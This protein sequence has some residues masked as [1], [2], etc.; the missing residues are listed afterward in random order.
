MKNMNEIKIFCPA[1]VANLSCGFDIIGLC[2][3]GI[4]DE[5]IIKKT[6]EKGI[7]ISVITGADLPFEVSKNV[8]GVAA[9]S[10]YNHLQPECGFEIEIHKKIK[11]GSGIGSS[12]ASAAGAVVGINELLGNP[13]SKLELVPFGMDGEAVASGCYHADNVA[14]AI[15]GGFSLIRGYEPLD[16][17]S[18][19]SPEEL[20][21]VVIHPHIEIKTSEARAVLPKEIPLGKAIIQWGNVAGLVAGLYTSNYDLIGRSVNDCI[22]EPARK[23]L[24][25]HF[26]TIKVAAIENGAL[27]SGISGSGPSIFA[28]CKGEKRALA[29]KDKFNKLGEEFFN[30]FDVH[31]SKVNNQG[32]CIVSN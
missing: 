27:N 29:V 9:L 2:L 16:I 24:I 18:I 11:I 3:D 31:C 6:P 21:V 32:A 4:G 1:T 20:Y 7:K 23:S 17:I 8:A 5:M 19:T 28:L 22:V 25:P 26:Q 30:S 15:L 14:P 12:S 10:L 13:L